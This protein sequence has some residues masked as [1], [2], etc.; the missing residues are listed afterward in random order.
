MRVAYN[1]VKSN[2]FTCSLNICILPLLIRAV[3]L[4]HLFAICELY[5][6]TSLLLLSFFKR[7]LLRC[8]A[9]KPSAWAAAGRRICVMSNL[10]LHSV[11]QRHNC[12]VIS[13]ES[14]NLLHCHQMPLEIEREDL[15]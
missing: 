4:L 15:F 7:F 2:S 3:G 5:C 13:A 9:Y 8:L 11:H 6:H 12:L 10:Q 14:T 1:I